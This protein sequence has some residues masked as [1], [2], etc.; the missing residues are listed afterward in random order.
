MQLNLITSPTEDDL[1]DL[2]E[3]QPT[4]EKRTGPLS[5]LDKEACARLLPALVDSETGDTVLMIPQV[6]DSR[7]SDRRV[8]ISIVGTFSVHAFS[9]V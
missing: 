5:M 8:P 4:V 9:T 3:E 2:S 1:D 6:S 7:G